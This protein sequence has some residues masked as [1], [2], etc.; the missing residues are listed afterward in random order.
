MSLRS[1][2]GRALGL[3]SV[4]GGTQHWWAQRVTAVAMIP[5]TLWLVFSLLLLPDLDYETARAWLR[6]PLSGFLACLLVP[7]VAY[8]SYLGVAVVI[9]D[10]VHGEGLKL[11][12]L[13]VSKFLH[14]LAAGAGIFAILHVAFG[15]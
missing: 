15:N 2:L 9:E 12:G 4:K 8:H 1:P 13:L 7:V 14:V 6:D 11:L 3:G 5:L 10:Y